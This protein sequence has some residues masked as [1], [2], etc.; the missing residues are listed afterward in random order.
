MT[1]ECPENHLLTLYVK[2]GFDNRKYGACPFCQR[3]FMILMLKVADGGKQLSLLPFKR[4]LFPAILYKKKPSQ[5]L[6]N[7]RTTILIDV[8][9]VHKSDCSFVVSKY[10]FLKEVFFIFNI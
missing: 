2:A 1:Y 5:F 9:C 10:E 7:K 6:F 8:E 3:I 4:E